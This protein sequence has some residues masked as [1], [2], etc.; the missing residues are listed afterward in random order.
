MFLSTAPIME[1]TRCNKCEQIIIQWP[2]EDGW[3]H[4]GD[5]DWK[6]CDE[7]GCFCNAQ[8]PEMAKETA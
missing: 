5:V 8:P 7:K 6:L 1:Y 2:H 3:N 4:F